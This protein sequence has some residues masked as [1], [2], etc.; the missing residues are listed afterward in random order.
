M[1]GSSSKTI[2]NQL[3]EVISNI[4][5]E[6]VQ[7]CLVTADQS[8]VINVNNS[9]WSIFGNYTLK[10]STEVASQCFSDV[11][12]QVDLQNKIIA[13]IAQ[14]STA[15][16]T[17]ILSAFGSSSSYAETNL[18][19]IIRN[20]VTMSNIQKNY[21]IIKQTQTAN[22]NN[23]G[24]SLSTNVNLTQG[25][26]V[27]AVSTLQE[28]DKAGIFNTISTHIDQEST[29]KTDSPFNLFGNLFGDLGTGLKYLFVFIVVVVIG[30][31]LY[32]MKASFMPDE[33]DSAGLDS[34][35]LDAAG[36]DAN[37]LELSVSQTEVEPQI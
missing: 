4:A 6:T 36:P 33:S 24:F 21:N 7:D 15:Q 34:T 26:D 16:G 27:F 17:G 28:I 23:A 31:M 19:S 37:G 18:T 2:I 12:K 8:Q 22:I 25:A 29:A 10:Q 11:K 14:T 35:G 5:M 9:G 32:K 30:M 3:S 13:A 20:N 1:G